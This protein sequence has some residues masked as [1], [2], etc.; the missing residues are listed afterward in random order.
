MTFPVSNPTSAQ[1]Q[2]GQ[3]PAGPSHHY[4]KWSENDHWAAPD[5]RGRPTNCCVCYDA[6]KINGTD[7]PGP[8]EKLLHLQMFFLGFFL[9]VVGS[10]NIMGQQHCI[11]LIHQDSGLCALKI[12]KPAFTYPHRRPSITTTQKMASW[13]VRQWSNLWLNNENHAVTDSPW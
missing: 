10:Y 4:Q 8:H 1:G 9:E 13:N 5:E 11:I 3:A 2:L 7:F 6:V 12:L